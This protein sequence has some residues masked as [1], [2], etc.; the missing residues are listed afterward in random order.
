[1]KKRILVTA[2]ITG[3][4]FV[5]CGDG[6]KGE[7]P[8]PKIEVYE[9]VEQAVPIISEFV[10]SVAG[11]K[12]IAI[13]ARAIGFLEGIHFDEGR[14]VKKGKLLYTIESQQYESESAAMQSKLAEAKTNLAYTESDLARIRPLAE[15]NAVSKSDLDAAVAKNDAAK[16]NV[17]AAKANLRAANIL[18]GYTKIKSPI[19]GIIGKTKAKVGDFVGQSPNPVILNV[20]SSID[21]I[22]VDFFLRES[23]Y[24]EIFRKY[25]DN[26]EI[27]NPRRG[28][29]NLELV[30]VDG[31]IFE[32]KGFVKF[33]DREVD[34]TTGAILVQ[35]AFPNTPEGLIRPGQFAKIRATVD[36]VENGILIPQRCIME[37]QGIHSVFVVTNK[38]KVESREVKTG[39]TVG[40]SWLIEEGLKAGEKIVY[41]GL[42]KVKSGMTVEPIIKK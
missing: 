11:Q 30:L 7:M 12:D 42:Q 34:P 21:T 41:E 8:I 24:L 25:V 36:V 38:N 2:I 35:A 16:A 1:M 23:Y 19:T 15:N 39:P 6:G 9:V 33:I 10:G 31:T 26:K 14:V 18:L 37:I 20:V 27:N 17:D 22:L 40:S 3:L 4:L 5:S 29:T 28:K 32:N 13:R